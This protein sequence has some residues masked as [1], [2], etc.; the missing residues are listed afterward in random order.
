MIS[1]MCEIFKNGTNDLLMK[2]N[3]H[4]KQIYGYPGG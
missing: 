2:Q 1:L 3:R 4:R